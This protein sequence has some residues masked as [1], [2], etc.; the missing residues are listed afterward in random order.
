MAMFKLFGAGRFMG[1]SA[2]AAPV[3]GSGLDQ[4]HD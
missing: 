4:I 2:L 1:R 3:A